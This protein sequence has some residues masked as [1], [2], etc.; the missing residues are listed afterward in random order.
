[1]DSHV[2]M[3]IFSF[4]LM[5]QNDIGSYVPMVLVNG[6]SS[7]ELSNEPSYRKFCHRKYINVAWHYAWLSSV[8]AS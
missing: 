2:D 5:L 6:I 3:G 4:C 7:G 8:N 1:M